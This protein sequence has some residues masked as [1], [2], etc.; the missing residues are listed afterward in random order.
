M[1]KPMD[2]TNE[3][4]KRLQENLNEL[5]HALNGA[6]PA[7]DQAEIMKLFAGMFLVEYFATI[8]EGSTM[9]REQLNYVLR[10][11]LGNGYNWYA[12]V[13]FLTGERARTIYSDRE[14]VFRSLGGA[15]FMRAANYVLPDIADNFDAL[16]PR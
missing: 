14:S 12:C 2:I 8:E 10:K 5:E 6:V 7:V 16:F 3:Y 15:G 13:K 4:C 9:P 11:T 1:I